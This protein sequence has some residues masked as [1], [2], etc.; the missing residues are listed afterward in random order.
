MRALFV[1]SL[2]VPILVVL[3][4]SAC[5][6]PANGPATWEVVGVGDLD[7]GA[8]AQVARAESA[9][10]AL[11][12]DMFELFAKV[13]GGN[14]AEPDLALCGPEAKAIAERVAADQKVQVGRTS[15]RLRNPANA[16]PEWAAPFVA[17]EVEEEVYVRHADGRVGA[18]F[19][20]RM[21]TTCTVCHGEPDRMDEGVKAL[22]A[23][24]YPDDRATGFAYPGLRG[25]VWVMVPPAGP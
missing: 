3:G 17:D 25:Y 8:Q 5:G 13:M 7:A 12:H 21:Q 23:Q 19:P 22:L 1:V 16:P 24:H 4:L 20:I 18:L 2:L 14:D 9:R 6:K 11:L 10:Q 15:F